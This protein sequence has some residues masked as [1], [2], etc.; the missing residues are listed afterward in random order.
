MRSLLLGEVSDSPL[1]CLKTLLTYPRSFSRSFFCLGWRVG[2]FLLTG[3]NVGESWLS[4]D[5]RF[6]E[7]PSVG[8]RRSEISP[9]DGDSGLV[10]GDF[11]FPISQFG[12][13]S[14]RS[15]SRVVGI[16]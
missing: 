3:C 13:S 15:D 1:S 2:D 8:L 4:G 7:E 9:A 10:L 5:P 11:C 14:S 16:D 6:C 12:L